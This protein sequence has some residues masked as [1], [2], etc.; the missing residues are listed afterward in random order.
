MAQ[1]SPRS[2]DRAEAESGRD[3][4][5]SDDQPMEDRPLSTEPFAP[6]EPC[7]APPPPAPPHSTD[8]YSDW[9]VATYLS[10]DDTM[11]LS[12]AQRILYAIDRFLPLPPQ[13]LRR[14]ELLNYF[15]FESVPVDRGNDFSVTGSLAPK[16]GAPSVFSLALAVRGRPV[17]RASR[18]NLALTVLVDRSGSM[19]DEGRMTYLK[20]GLRRMLRELKP[21]DMLNLV[22]FN[23]SACVPLQ[24][25]VV[26]RDPAETL[27]KAIDGIAPQGNTDL[28]TGLLRAYQ[29]ADAS[30]RPGFNHRVLLITDALAN[31]G[32]TDPELMAIVSR[33]YDA[34][35]IRLSGI[36]VGREFN[37]RLLDRLTDRGKGAYVFLGSEAEVDAVFGDRFVSLVET[38]AL[39]THFLL[40]LPPSLRMNAF[41]GEESSTSREEVQPVHYFAGTS[42]LFLADIMVKRGELRSGDMIMLG[43]EYRDP[44]TGEQRLEEHA[45]RLGDLTGSQLNV[46]KAQL[47]VEFVD[48]LGW[49]ASRVPQGR[50]ARAERRGWL[51]DDAAWECEQRGRRL[52]EMGRGIGGDPEVRRITGLWQRYCERFEPPR[53][54]RRGPSPDRG[55][56]PGAVGPT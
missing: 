56:W 10:N 33:F 37:D 40:H 53:G 34:R 26:G 39:D 45:L 32:D 1:S 19:R 9:G 54:Q 8:S 15:S 47:V 43:I 36:G 13:H 5:G 12:S 52:E 29:L 51:D 2:V 16:D 4:I 38:T 28:Q 44:E 17:D 46:K 11:S 3:A 14:H 41:Y 22:T 31:T 55:T 7:P 18:R 21:G 25:F 35:Q 30:Y 27:E 42:Q 20:R 23:T 6:P 49:M 24:S 48:G 50:A